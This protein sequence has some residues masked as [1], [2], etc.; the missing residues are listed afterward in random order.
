MAYS[1]VSRIEEK[2]T[3]KQFTIVIVSIVGIIL[4]ITT[5]GIPLMV[6]AS[7]FLG[8]LKSQQPLMGSSDKTPPFPPILSPVST[9]TNSASLKIEGYGE[10][11][12]TLKIFVNEQEVKN[13]LIGVDGN[14]SFNDISLI[15]GKNEIYGISRDASGNE[16]SSSDH[17]IVTYKK[18]A[19]KLEINEPSEGTTFGKNQQEITIRGLTDPRNDVRINDRFVS[20][21]DDGSFTYNL[22]LN[23]GE[24]TLTIIARDAA[25]NETKLER[26]VTYQP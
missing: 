15:S 10:P 9:A 3:R 19:P 24:N 16:S 26:K 5:I 14:F 13:I 12:S 2:R 22:R 25:G 8:N 11:E 18:N 4:V 7:V 1:R 21:K 23:D 17:L 20:V 6:G